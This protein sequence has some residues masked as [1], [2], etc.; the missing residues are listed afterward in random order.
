[1][2]NDI[3]QQNEPVFSGSSNYFY[4][5]HDLYVI[6]LLLKAQNPRIKQ[7]S[8]FAARRY[9]DTED[10]NTPIPQSFEVRINSFI[11]NSSFSWTDIFLVVNKRPGAMCL[12]F[13]ISTR[14]S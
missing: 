8:I 1:M 12:I 4:L 6:M 7:N 5:M 11:E 14:V 2:E 3:L 13:C 10:S 9:Q